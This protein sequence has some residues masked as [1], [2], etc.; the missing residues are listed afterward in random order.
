MQVYRYAQ[1]SEVEG[2]V[3]LFPE[4]LPCNSCIFFVIEQF[5]R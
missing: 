5:H 1:T 3:N 4:R 2:A